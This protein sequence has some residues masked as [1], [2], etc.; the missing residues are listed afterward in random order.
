M[1][2][3]I[4]YLYYYIPMEQCEEFRKEF[5]A[6]GIGKLNKDYKYSGEGNCKVRMFDINTGS[7]VSSAW[8]TRSFKFWFSKDEDRV[9]CDLAL[10]SY[11]INYRDY[12][13][14]T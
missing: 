1:T 10:Y 14:K 8:N 4:R 7:H 13:R 9:L 2:T 5:N 11:R 6:I 3:L 12:Q